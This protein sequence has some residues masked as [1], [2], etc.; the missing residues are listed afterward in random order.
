MAMKRLLQ[1]FIRHLADEKGLTKNTLE[2]YERDLSHYIDY[3]EKQG[4]LSLEQSTKTNIAQYLHSLKQLGRAPATISR[5]MVSIRALYQYLAKER[6]ISH[7][8]S[9]H[10]ETPKIERR[11]PKVLTVDEVERLLEAPECG[12]PNGMRDKA[13]L[14]LLYATGIRVSELISLDVADVD[15]GMG[16]VRCKGSGSRERIVP[17]GRIAAQ[18]LESYIR[19]MRP[20]LLRHGRE[21]EALFINHHGSR[22]TRQ[23][24]WKIMKRYASESGTDKVITPHTLRHSFATHLLE[25]GADLKSVQ[26]M[27]GHADIST[28]QVYTHVTSTRMKDIY[29]RAHPRAQLRQAPAEDQQSGSPVSRSI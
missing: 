29:D 28:T 7:D 6:R 2:S 22:L 18:W 25:N 24:F 27:L 10:L 21:Q 14:E 16:F 8:P 3:I 23:G 13:M 12:S 15:M 17:L 4:V 1:T 20:Q 11:L 19:T 9:L 5:N 26:E